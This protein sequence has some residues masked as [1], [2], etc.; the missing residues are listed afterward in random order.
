MSSVISRFSIAG[1]ILAGG[2]GRRMGG[3]DKG[4]LQVA[5]KPLIAW[6]IERLAPQAAQIMVSANRNHAQ[7]LQHAGEV[8]ADEPYLN[9]GQSQG[10]DQGQD[11]AGPLAGFLASM[12]ATRAPYLLTLP[13]DAPFAPPDL[14]QRLARALTHSNAHIAVAQVGDTLHPVHALMATSLLDNLAQA[15]AQGE[16]SVA[17]WCTAQTC[18]QVNFDDQS[19]AFININTPELLALQT[20]RITAK[21]R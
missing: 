2:A 21:Y 4:L 5:G 14:S 8:V 11:Y 18:V 16:R 20:K 1:S 10:E 13:C 17:R 9:P 7:Y 12:R 15:L 6:A 3:A 19:E